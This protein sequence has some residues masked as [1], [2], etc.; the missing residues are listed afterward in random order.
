MPVAYVRVNS[1]SPHCPTDTE[2]L[3]QL[4]RRLAER[5]VKRKSLRI[6]KL[7]LQL[8]RLRRLQFGRSSE[9]LAREIEQLELVIEEMQRGRAAG[10]HAADGA[11]RPAT[12]PQKPARRPLPTTCR[13]RRCS[14]RPPAPAPTAAARCAGSARTSPRCWTTC[15]PRSR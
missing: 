8:S 5:S 7:R 11:R 10:A 2:A 1:I 12:D 9:K 15:R 3:R 14:T 13:A 4:V 6:A